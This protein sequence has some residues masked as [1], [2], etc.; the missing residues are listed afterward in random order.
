MRIL[1]QISILTHGVDKVITDENKI[2]FR[3]KFLRKIKG[4]KK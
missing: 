1:Q 4:D 3:I 2:D